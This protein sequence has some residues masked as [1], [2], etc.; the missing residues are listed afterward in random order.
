MNGP[1]TGGDTSRGAVHLLPAS[2]IQA[3]HR[4]PARIVQAA[5]PTLRAPEVHGGG[6]SATPA[7]GARKPWRSPHQSAAGFHSPSRNRPDRGEPG[8][9]DPLIGACSMS[10]PNTPVMSLAT[11]DSLIPAS[12][13]SCSSPWI[14]RPRFRVG[15]TRVR[16]RSRNSRIGPVAPRRPGPGRALRVGPATPHPSWV[17]AFPIGTGRVPGTALSKRAFYNSIAM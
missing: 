16:V 7:L 4:P 12:S 14:S 3:L 15:I 9:F 11:L 8:V 2:N 1:L 6:S 17:A 10:R 13:S 5:R